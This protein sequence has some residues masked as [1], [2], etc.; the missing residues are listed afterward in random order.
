MEDDVSSPGTMLGA[1][2]DLAMDLDFMDDLLFD[3]CWLEAMDGSEFLHQNPSTSGAQLDPSL[4]WPDL[5]ANDNWRSNPS[6]TGNEE[7]IQRPL[8]DESQERSLVSAA[9]LGQDMINVARCSS[10]SKN[11]VIEGSELRTRWWIAPSGNPGCANSVTHRLVNAIGYL[12]EFTRDKGVLIQIWVPV[13]RG[14]GRVLTTSNQPFSLDSSCPRLAR[15]RDISRKFQFSAEEDSRELVGLPGRVFLDKV[16]EWTPD[17]RFFRSDEY[18]RVGHAQHYNICGT[19]ALPIF[20]Q[21]SRTC[22]GVIEVVMTTQQIK[23]FPEVESVR[24]AL[25]A[26]DLRSSDALSTDNVKA[27]NMAY[28]AALPEIKEVL[29]SACETHGLPLAQTWVP[30]I[31]QGKAGCRHSDDNYVNCVS[32]V[33]HACVVADPNMQGFHEACSEHH[34]LKG[35]GIV[36]RAFRTNQPCFSADITSFGKTEYPLSHHARVFGLCAAVAIHLRSIHTGTVDFV[37]EFFLP[38]NCTDSVEQKKMLSSL[39]IIVQHVCRSLRIVTDKELEEDTNLSVNEKPRREEML[40]DEKSA[41]LWQHRQDSKLE[42]NIEFGEECSAYDEGIFPS[43]G[44][45]KAGEK[46][47]SRVE[48]TITME[49]LR[50]YFAGSLKDAAKNIGV[51]STT[52]KRICRQNGIKRWPSRQIKKV[53]HSLQKIQ[54]VIDSVHGTSGAFEI[55]SFYTN[56]PELTSPKLSGTG[57]LSARKLSEYTQP[58]SSMQPEGELFSPQ[59]AAPKSTSSSCSQAST[60]SHSCSSGTHQHPPTW[61]IAHFE[62]AII[63][64]NR[65]Q[66]V[67]SGISG[68]AEIQAPSQGPKLLP[69]SQSH[70]SNAENL[71]PSLKDSGHVAQE[72]YAQKVKVTYGDERV[73]FRVQ[74]NWKY[75][76]LLLEIARR[77]YI[78]DMSRFNLKYLDDD[79]EWILLTCDADWEE[80][81]NVC[82]SSQSHT[83]KLSLQVSR[84]QLGS[85]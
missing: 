57:P 56:F 2:A 80:C 55:N 31:Q 75:T 14:N 44:M 53:G 68:A 77:F 42:R 5:K 23:Y 74:N 48:K 7:E 13:N 45:S 28:L 66:D 50:Q 85:L 3:G 62:D 10:E 34:L 41:E 32:T 1:R 61:N 59:A 63:G 73:R 27:C 22:F 43:V 54:L 20:E 37:L 51:C 30:C 71:V 46:R 35:Q 19:L 9:S 78:D 82:Q 38:V 79:A 40:Y 69:K 15:Y 47:R 24:K 83:I 65:H 39:S 12:R 52:L 84:H 25:E 49:V 81:I 60:S 58:S 8:P 33:D 36:G 64:E 76:D 29:R 11:N 16:P 70:Q 21:G 6:Q 4:E 26:V 17:V 67:L 72:W 18:P